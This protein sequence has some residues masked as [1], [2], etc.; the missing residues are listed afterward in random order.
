M[1]TDLELEILAMLLQAPD[2][3]ELVK[4]HLLPEMFF[5]AT[6]GRVFQA[7]VAAHEAGQ[8][9]DAALLAEK[10]Q[11]DSAALEA[12]ADAAGTM[13]YSTESAVEIAKIIA[14]RWRARQAGF[15]GE[16]LLKQS[17]DIEAAQA[18]LTRLAETR[19]DC[20][21]G[22][23][24][25]TEFSAEFE[26]RRQPA[27]LPW[28]ALNILI[29][30]GIRPGAL[31]ILAGPKG[32][33]K[34]LLAM[35][36]FIHFCRLGIPSRLLPLEDS[37]ADFERRILAFLSGSWQPIHTDARNAG[38]RLALLDQHANEIE[39]LIRRVEE[40]PRRRLAPD[41]EISPLPWRSVVGWARKA[42]R[43]NEIVFI[44]PFAQIDFCGPRSWEEEGAFARA[45]SGLAA[46]AA[47][48]IVLV[49]HT[50]KR[51][52][53]A[54]WLDATTEDVQGAAN[55]TRLAHLVLLLQ[56]HDEKTSETL[57]GSISHNRTVIV[58]DARHGPGRG[59][60][61]AFRMLPGGRFEELGVISPPRS[62]RKN[63]GRNYPE[64]K[65]L[66]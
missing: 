21:R 37:R 41:G 5:S 15:V 29:G 16:R 54:A 47:K 23:S 28:P 56:A 8:P 65:D 43:N 36:L 55:L 58:G 60:K 25:E 49:C 22:E 14:E 18:A 44:D 26:G 11:A 17:V 33:G 32:Q 51:P 27:A 61:V 9:T 63:I 59:Q 48:R 62:G 52:G 2:K 3:I 1:N 7:I 66:D 20:T 53:K 31:T 19:F 30:E 34:T 10:F 46:G 39:P 38:A 35:N 12:L 57:S 42:L 6:H 24:L 13:V 4:G 64:R 45:L 40:N 50:S